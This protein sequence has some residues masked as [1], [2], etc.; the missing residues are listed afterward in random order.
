MREILFL[1]FTIILTFIVYRICKHISYEEGGSGRDGTREFLVK[2]E[3]SEKS[4]KYGTIEDDMKRRFRREIINWTGRADKKDKKGGEDREGGEGDI[5]KSTIYRTYAMSN[6]YFLKPLVSE[7]EYEK[8]EKSIR[9]SRGD[10]IPRYID[11]RTVSSI[12]RG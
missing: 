3:K 9:L 1:L 10:G 11:Y 8:L 7:Y 5:L 12:L 2:K 6:L 4:E